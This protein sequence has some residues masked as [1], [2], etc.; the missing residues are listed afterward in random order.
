MQSIRFRLSVL[1]SSLVFGAGAVV[2]G[3]IYLSLRQ[4]LDRQPVYQELSI[5]PTYTVRDGQIFTLARLTL[6]EVESLERFVNEQT[7]SRLSTYSFAALG[8]LFLISLAIG[9]FVAG[10]A[11][12]PVHRITGVAR[13]IQATDLALRIDLGGPN[14]ELR[15]LAD[16][17]DAM[18]DR[19]E[20]GF[21]RQRQFIADVSHDLRNPLAV[22]QTNAEVALN[23]PKTSITEWR[24]T[25]EIVGTTA[26]RMS[27]L[28]E[29]LLATARL[30]HRQVAPEHV[31]LGALVTEA[32]AEMAVPARRRSVEL[33]TV[34]GGT[35]TIAGDRFA[36]ER[37]VANVLDNAVRLSPAGS[38][39]RVGCGRRDG[40]AWL[41][42]EDH[43]PGIDPD[44][45]EQIFERYYHA[46]PVAAGEEHPGLGLTIVREIAEAHGGTVGVAST[47]GEGTTFTIWLPLEP[48]AGAEPPAPLRLL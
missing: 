44:R 34:V 9:W 16:T 43:G 21:E 38:A 12:R 22:I 35:V 14:D 33:E 32:V 1:Y 47:P 37:A 41:A 20:L 46:G 18:L 17:F 30:Q 28:V 4:A 5:S 31:D 19:L 3:A 25:A 26:E 11:L 2:V 6:T 15:E 39:V 42:V 27:G 7:L 45:L 24:R 48:G 13:D 40:W 10:R 36:L 8:V 29:G 23:D